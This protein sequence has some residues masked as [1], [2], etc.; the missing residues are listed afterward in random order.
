MPGWSFVVSSC[1]SLL[2]YSCFGMFWIPSSACWKWRMISTSLP[3]MIPTERNSEI[4]IFRKAS[5]LC[6]TPTSTKLQE[7]V[8]FFA[9]NPWM[10]AR[11]WR[12]MSWYRFWP[13][14]L[15]GEFRNSDQGMIL[16]SKYIQC[17][18]RFYHVLGCF[19]AFLLGVWDVFCL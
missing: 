3:K 15:G 6:S 5:C 17:L 2:R 14:L 10:H 19:S 18:H 8:N 16:R 7:K 9:R 1:C 4:P 13:F 11:K 12:C